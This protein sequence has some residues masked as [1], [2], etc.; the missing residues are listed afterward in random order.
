[1]LYG[2]IWCR[3]RVCRQAFSGYAGIGLSTPFHRLSFSDVCASFVQR[4]ASI[5]PVS[6]QTPLEISSIPDYKGCLSEPSLRPGCSNSAS[7]APFA[8]TKCTPAPPEDNY[9]AAVCRVRCRARFCLQLQRPG[10]APA[11]GGSGPIR[12]GGPRPLGGPA[13]TL[14][15]EGCC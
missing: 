3:L 1:M 12:P 4:L 15:H 7:S 5:L 13:W 10:R 14:L 6:W 11:P 8:P 2:R 9:T